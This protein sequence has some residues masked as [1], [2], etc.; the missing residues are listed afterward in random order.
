MRG[1]TTAPSLRTDPPECRRH[2]DTREPYPF[3]GYLCYGN[4]AVRS[5]TWHTWFGSAHVDQH[6]YYR[7][8]QIEK[9]GLEQDV[10]T[11]VTEKEQLDT[12]T[13]SLEK[14]KTELERGNRWT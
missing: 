9:K 13:Q 7:Q 8:C 1:S 10:A 3:S 11:L 12:E 4:G 2:H 6:E 5:G 14:R